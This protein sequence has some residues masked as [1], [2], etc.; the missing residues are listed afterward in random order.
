MTPS[1]DILIEVAVRKATRLQN[2]QQI[3]LTAEPESYWIFCLN[4]KYYIGWEVSSSLIIPYLNKKV[5]ELEVRGKVEYKI[6][7]LLMN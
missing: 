1:L 3:R 4:K 6:Q 7:S 5:Y 2:N